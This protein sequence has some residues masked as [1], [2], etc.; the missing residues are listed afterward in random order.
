MTSRP[1]RA[2]ESWRDA[3]TAAREAEQRLQQAWNE[4]ALGM[5]T[6]PARELIQEVTHLRRIAHEKLTAAIAVIGSEVHDH[7]GKPTQSRAERP[8]S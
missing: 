8:S 6:P 5:A 2:F 1:G 4:Y 3:D 7:R